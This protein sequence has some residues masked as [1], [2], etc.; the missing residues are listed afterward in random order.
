MI[1]AGCWISVAAVESEVFLR[2]KVFLMA[3]FLA[4]VWLSACVTTRPTPTSSASSAILVPT[5]THGAPQQNVLPGPT[6]EVSPEE[7]VYAFLTMYGTDSDDL[8]PYLSS[9]LIQ[10]L[11][12]G[13]II[14]Y[15]DF[16]GPLEGLVFEAGSSGQ[17]PSVAVV[18]ARMQVNGEETARTFYLT[19]QDGYWLIASI[20]KPNK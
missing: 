11:P 1:F 4:L 14:E 18:K 7:V 15:L 16:N 20:E 6:S 9:S 10:Q 12:P 5:A 13:G 8:M 3:S 2:R 19:L 17:D